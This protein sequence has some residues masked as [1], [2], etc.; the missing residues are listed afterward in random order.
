MWF[1]HIRKRYARYVKAVITALCATTMSACYID[2]EKELCE[3]NAQIV[4]RYARDMAKPVN[5]ISSYIQSITEYIFDEDDVL[6]MINT[7]P[8]SSCLGY[9]ISEFTLPAGRYTLVSWANVNG[10][11]RINGATTGVTTLDEIFFILDAPHGE[12]TKAGRDADQISRNSEK[13]YY[14]YRRFAVEETGISRVCVDMFNAHCRLTLTINWKSGPPENTRDFYLLY[15]D[16]PAAYDFQ[17]GYSVSVDG[18]SLPDPLYREFPS[19]DRDYRHYAPRRHSESPTA[20]HRRDA[21]MTVDKR[22]KTEFITYRYNNDSKLLLSLY[23][24]E[25]QIMKEIDLQRFFATVGID[26]DRNL[27]QEFNLRIEIDNVND[28]VNVGFVSVT[29]WEEGGYISGGAL[30]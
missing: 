7:L 27:R 22:I 15:S 21:N 3:Y 19:A 2:G 17:P 28:K 12:E 25:K 23:A 29:D 5:Q 16:V 10:A 4:Y 6:C 30:N 13:L 11:S 9:N 20:T 26:L 1:R 14:G 18:W 24:G 8:G